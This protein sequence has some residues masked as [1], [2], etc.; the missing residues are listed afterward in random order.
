MI[1]VSQFSRGKQRYKSKYRKPLQVLQNKSENV[2]QRT[3]GFSLPEGLIN[4]FI[5]CRDVL[6][7]KDGVDVSWR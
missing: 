2:N 1:W 3:E 4:R 6:N 5:K 7:L